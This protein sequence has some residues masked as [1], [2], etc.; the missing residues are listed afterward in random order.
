VLGSWLRWDTI[1]YLLIAETGYTA[2]PGLTVW[3]PLYPA[4]VRLLSYLFG[5]SLLAALVISSLAAWLA[6]FLLYLLV[7]DSHDEGTAR[8][9]L[10][11]YVVYPLAFFL[12]AGYTESLFLALVLGSLLLARKK[13][14]VWAGILAALATLTRN[15]GILL[16]AVLLWEGLL[17]YREEHGLQRKE[18][19]EVLFASSLPVLTFGAF[20]VYIHNGLHAGWPWETL[21][22][23]WGQ[24]TGFP[25][26]GIIGNIK[27]LLTL[28]VSEDLYWLPANVI[29]LFL[30]ILIPLVLVTY[31]HSVRSTYLV[32]AWLILIMSLM[33]LGPDGTLVSFSR[34]MLAGFPFFILLAPVVTSRYAR[35][36]VF[37]ICLVL[38]AILLSMFYI[39]S[40]AG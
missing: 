29:D 39:W 23:I 12:V 14:W 26:E 18:S 35:L 20:A 9:T 4:L 10:F 8:K 33:K 2:H 30:A 5:S 17:Q 31:R 1:C 13:A 32:F 34:Y 36:A 21:A 40:W 6:F 28:P 15:Q 22:A 37:G 11:F 19:L 25:W 7:A 3:P 24:Y 38:Q 27:Q 16:S